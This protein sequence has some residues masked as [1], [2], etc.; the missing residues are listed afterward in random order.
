MIFKL[1]VVSCPLEIG[2]VRCSALG[3]QQC[4]LKSS[5]NLQTV[6]NIPII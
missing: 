2:P 5:G 4:Y 3:R 6:I 1:T